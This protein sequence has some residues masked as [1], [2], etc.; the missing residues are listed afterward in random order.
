MSSGLVGRPTLPPSPCTR[1]R[2]A[3]SDLSA[4]F[5]AASCLSRCLSFLCLGPGK[6]GD[7]LGPEGIAHAAPCSLELKPPQGQTRRERRPES[8]RRR[9]CIQA[10]C[11]IKVPP[12]SNAA[13]WI[14]GAASSREGGGLPGASRRAARAGE[15]VVEQLP[16][17]LPA[18]AVKLYEPHLLDGTEIGR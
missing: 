18:C 12:G 10:T 4:S 6:S 9:S 11:A 15:G 8:A 16:D 17:R 13:G 3:T 1:S 14:P 2:S 5:A 7:D